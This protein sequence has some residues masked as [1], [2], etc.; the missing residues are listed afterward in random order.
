MYKTTVFKEQQ[1]H[2]QECREE[3]QASLDNRGGLWGCLIEGLEAA[4]Q[5][6]SPGFF[7]DVLIRFTHWKRSHNY[8]VKN[9]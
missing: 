3:K 4:M 6:Q 5:R 7:K 1:E 2:F 9:R 8:C